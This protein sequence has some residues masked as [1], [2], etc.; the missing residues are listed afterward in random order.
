MVFRTAGI[1]PAHEAGGTAAVHMSMKD[2]PLDWRAPS[3]SRI[4]ASGGRG[5]V[6][7]ARVS[8]SFRQAYPAQT[9]RHGYAE[10]PDIVEESDAPDCGKG[11]PVFPVFPPD[12]FGS[13]SNH[14]R[15]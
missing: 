8:A 11:F 10:A 9:G 13:P 7:H 5:L 1:L 3:N 4:G 12:L 15:D 2:A 6:A 14:R